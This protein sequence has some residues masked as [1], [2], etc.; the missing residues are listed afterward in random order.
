MTE[1][2]SQLPLAH[3]MECTLGLIFP[4]MVGVSVYYLEKPPTACNIIACSSKK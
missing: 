2:L 4:V 3:T 1:C